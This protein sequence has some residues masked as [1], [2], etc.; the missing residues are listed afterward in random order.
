MKRQLT[1]MSVAFSFSSD[2]FLKKYEVKRQNDLSSYFVTLF[3][4]S[5]E[6][7]A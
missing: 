2:F 6:R 5:S 3:V 4:V 7:P 1:T